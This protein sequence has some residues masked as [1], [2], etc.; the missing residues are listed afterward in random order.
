MLEILSRSG[1]IHRK[2]NSLCSKST[3]FIE[4][5]QSQKQFYSIM[6][7]YKIDANRIL[8]LEGEERALKA[9]TNDPYTEEQESG[10][11][12]NKSKQHYEALVSFDIHGSNHCNGSKASM[13]MGGHFENRTAELYS[14]LAFTVFQ[15]TVISPQGSLLVHRGP[16][17]FKQSQQ[18]ENITYSLILTELMNNASFRSYDPILFWQSSNYNRT[19][20]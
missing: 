12:Q 13:V 5:Q 17:R 18:C 4:A 3:T 10:T 15:P 20:L 11:P 6:P 8:D 2:G 1:S 14:S 19:A 7:I 16:H 9:I